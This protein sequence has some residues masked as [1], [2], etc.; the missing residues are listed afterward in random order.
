MRRARWLKR[1]AGARKRCRPS[2]RGRTRLRK[3]N[4]RRFKAASRPSRCLA[5]ACPAHPSLAGILAKAIR[6]RIGV[7]MS[8]EAELRR[9]A[10]V[11]YSQ[12]NAT[13]SR[14]VKRALREMGDNYQHEHRQM[15]MNRQ[16]IMIGRWE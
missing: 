4:G 5:R 10:D 3:G 9:L 15:V 16:M 14:A 12:A 7:S 11:Y 6:R 2:P 8:R 13:L 1:A